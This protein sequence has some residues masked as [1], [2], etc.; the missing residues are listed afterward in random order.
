MKSCSD[1]RLAGETAFLHDFSEYYYCFHRFVTTTTGGQKHQLTE[2]EGKYQQ[3]ITTHRDGVILS[4]HEPFSQQTSELII[5]A[6]VLVLI[7]HE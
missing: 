5:V 6:K 4:P 2:P 7:K 1:H 3:T